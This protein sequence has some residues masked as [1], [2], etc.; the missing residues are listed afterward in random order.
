MAVGAP[1]DASMPEIIPIPALR[2]NYIWLVRDGH[3]AAVVDPGDAAPVL[4]YLEREGLALTG[5]VIT[6]HHWDHVN[7]IE[8][9]TARFPVP[10]YGP[11]RESIPGRTHPVAEGD[12]FKVP[13]VA[14]ELSV[15]DVPGHTSG[16]V[17]YVGSCDG[18]RIAFN[19]QSGS[20]L[21]LGQ[22]L[23]VMAFDRTTMTFS[24][25]TLV[26]NQFE[27]HP[28]LEQSKVVAATQQAGL[29][30]T[31][32]SPI[33]RGR[34]GGDDLLAAIGARYDKTAGQV[35]L[36][37]LVQQQAIVIPRTSRVE[38]LSENI[39]VFDFELTGEEMAEIGGLARPDGR[40]VNLPW[41]PQWD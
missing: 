23:Y 40:I 12:V 21:K 1:E 33:A 36:R 31:A 27:W 20:G 41:A 25:A 24:G 37:W 19:P 15:V 32:Y 11:A 10:V 18:A 9:L 28:Y 35:S 38:R 39:E 13:E 14:L 8:A 30:V 16:Q 5:I 17:S 22:A 6:H 3:H 2:D 7:G 26:T 34:A 29:A 4:A